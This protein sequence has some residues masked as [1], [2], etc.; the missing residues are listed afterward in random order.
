[1]VKN[2]SLIEGYIEKNIYE[3][4]KKWQNSKGI[5]N[6]SLA[7]NCI[8]ADFFGLE[9]SPNKDELN[10]RLEGFEDKLG[11]LNNKVD[12]LTSAL[13]QV[14]K[15]SSVV[16]SDKLTVSSQT[17]KKTS[18]KK[19]VSFKDTNKQQQ[20]SVTKKSSRKKVK[21]ITSG[22]YEE[23]TKKELFKLLT[24][25]KIPHRISPKD[26]LKRKDEMVAELLVWD[27]NN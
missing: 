3:H 6:N 23:M 12:E 24:E 5:N 19:S 13:N 7:L 16:K 1:M 20:K 18:P 9:Y 10:Q 15:V 8:L 27:K 25:R 26:R 4:Y 14:L 21:E 11:S 17:K 2:T 22:N